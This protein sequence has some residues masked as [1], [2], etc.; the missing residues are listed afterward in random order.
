MKKSLTDWIDTDID[1]TIFPLQLSRAIAESKD[2]YDY[3][4]VNFSTANKDILHDGLFDV[5][6]MSRQHNILVKKPVDG[7]VEVV[8]NIGYISWGRR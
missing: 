8:A 5:L 3:H 4:I 1:A 2:E 7:I 6:G